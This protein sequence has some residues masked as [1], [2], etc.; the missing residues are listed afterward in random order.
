MFIWHL[1]DDYD[2]SAKW[3]L[4]DLQDKLK[5]SGWMVPAYTLPKS[6]EDIVVMRVVVKQGFTR[7]MADMMLADM[8]AAIAE[9]EQLK[10]PTASRIAYEKQEKQKGKVFTH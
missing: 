5:Q 1:D 9:L 7:D 6:L 8:K 10:F 2:K 3:T 4:Y